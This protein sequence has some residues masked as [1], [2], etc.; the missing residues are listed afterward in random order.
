MNNKSI[1]MSVLHSRLFIARQHLWESEKNHLRICRTLLSGSRGI[2]NSSEWH[3]PRQFNK[4]RCWIPM[5]RT[6]ENIFSAKKHHV[7][8][9][10]AAVETNWA[11]TRSLS[12]ESR[13]AIHV[14]F[15]SHNNNNNNSPTAPRRA[16]W[17]RLP[18][19]WNYRC[20]I[21]MG[22]RALSKAA[23]LIFMHGHSW[24]QMAAC[25]FFD[26]DFFFISAHTGLFIFCVRIES[27]SSWLCASAGCCYCLGAACATAINLNYFCQI[28]QNAASA[29]SMFAERNA[30]AGAQDKQ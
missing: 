28:N 21:L 18:A 14:S 7:H 17:Q 13:V 22:G 19:G 5:A 9:T 26:L 11:F 12:A 25:A 29:M 1:Q 4:R 30:A 27:S 3:S 23:R 16:L 10:T 24:M 2:Y 15:R 20:I 8:P 6:T